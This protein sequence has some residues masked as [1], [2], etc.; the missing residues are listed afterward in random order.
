VIAAQSARRR[1]AVVGRRAPGARR[2]DLWRILAPPRRTPA[3]APECARWRS[4][5]CDRGRQHMTS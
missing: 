5:S 3:P 4:A 2:Q 1:A